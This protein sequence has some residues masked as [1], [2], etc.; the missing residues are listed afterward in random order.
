MSDVKVDEWLRELG[1]SQYAQSFAANDIDFEVL[2][3]LSDADLKE[4][5]VASLGHRKRLLS[6]ATHIRSP[7]P[8]KPVEPAL[9][10]VGERRQ[11]TILFADLC[12]FTTLSQSLDPEEICDLV[13]RFT[14]LADGI[15][16]GYGGT[17]DKHIG[18]AVMAL[19]GAPVAHDDDPLRAARAALDIH[20]ELAR[21]SGGSPRELLAHIGVASGEVIAGGLNRMGAPDYTVLGE[22]V[23]LAARLVALAGPGQ[24]LLSEG[25][26]RAVADRCLCEPLGESQVKGFAAPVCIWRLSGPAEP[27]PASRSPF[28]GRVAE[29][30][31]F[32]GVLAATIAG[33][34]GHAIHVRGEAGIGKTRLV[35]EM[36]RLAEAGGFVTH[37]GLILDFGVGKEQGALRTLLFSLLGLPLI[38][39]D[40]ARRQKVDE[41]LAA[42]VVAEER[43][44]FLHDMLDLEQTGEWRKLYEA[45]DNSARIRG[46]RAVI[47]AVAARACAESPT[48]VIVEDL[49]WAD[50]PLLAHL[51]A[52]ATALADGAGLMVLTS[53]I[54]GDPID[55]A[56]RASCRGTSFAT[57]DIGPLRADEAL[58]LAGGFID[59]TQRVARACIERAGGNPLFLEQLLRHAREGA[60]EAIPP[61]LRSL[62]LARMDRLPARERQ[63]FQAAA[64]IGQR[65]DLGLLRQLIGDPGY[66]C[67]GLVGH[68]LV[69]P[70]GEDFLFAHALIQ[71]GAYASLLRSTRKTLHLKAAEWFE[72]KDSLLRAQHLDRADDE[73]AAGAYLAA[74]LSQRSVFRVEA[75][76]RSAERG[77]Q[78]ARTEGDRHELMCLIGDVQ[79]DRGEIG[80]SVASYRAA[81]EA[82]SDA[83]MRCRAEL[84]LAE[85]LRV[86]EGLDEALTL[87]DRAQETAESEQLVADL[88]RLHHLRGNIYFPIGNIEGCKVEHELGLDYAKRSGSAEAEARALGGLADAAYAQGKMRTAFGY[89]SRCVD[90]CQQ[91]GFGR[92]EVANRSMVGFSRAY[93]NEPLQ[94][95]ADGDA[96]ARVAAMVG[97]PRAELLGETMGVLGSYEMADFEAM[98]VYLTRALRLV[99]QLGAKRFEAQALELQARM[100]LDRG[101]RAEAEAL[102]REALAMCHD[103]GTQFCGP[104]VAGALSRAVEDPAERATFL[105]EGEAMLKRGSVGHNHL[106]FYRDAIE[107][108]LA[109]RD[110]GGAMNYVRALEDYT[111]DEPLP[112]AEIFAARGRALV[113]ALRGMDDA[114]AATLREIR[115]ALQRAGLRPFLPAIEAALAR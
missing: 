74:A 41:L 40:E 1:L 44:P 31:Q 22:S 78:I 89:F 88:A 13:A 70:E 64:V 36:R 104:K 86:N 45:M 58:A 28:V 111:R 56:W 102:L 15:V 99:R 101:E 50:A 114:V 92:I 18:D 19:F 5:G 32:K 75:A 67:D 10:E 79:R 14:A 61:S 65:F 110:A 98:Q 17:V 52:L 27:A 95:R 112:W 106:W 25:V 108:N 43:R 105:A 48:F 7:S 103:A 72:G 62:V 49:H 94:A 51:A 29:I 11:V 85:G 91:H 68:A 16:L 21:T 38:A 81:V 87:L 109:A 60:A 73:R 93:L 80:A 33:R 97:Q 42:Q 115:D 55:A 53:R 107:A 37:R 83:R 34:S 12:G 30:E 54:E 84:G 9:S 100:M 90:L 2:A 6:A 59:A 96:A 82:A 77:L 20:A 39:T 66:V 71:E 69:L 46:R 4:I 113:N 26:Y 8:A 3:D 47:A 76:L 35:E 24:T 63:A 23:N 57:L